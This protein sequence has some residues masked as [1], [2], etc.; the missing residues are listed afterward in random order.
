MAGSRK[1]KEE[2]GNAPRRGE[3][4]TAPPVAA[5]PGALLAPADSGTITLTGDAGAK[6]RL[7]ERAVGDLPFARP[8]RIPA[9]EHTIVVTRPPFEPIVR[10]LRL[11]PGEELRVAADFL[12]SAGY[13]RCVV[14]PWAE[15][16]VDGIYRETTPIDRPIAVTEGARTVRFHHPVFGDTAWQVAVARKETVNVTLVFR[17]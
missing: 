10:S 3:E 14:S 6:V 15:I 17:Q 8:L 5:A 12:E 1:Q 9:G 4:R 16:Y 7:D 13:L 2:K 11:G